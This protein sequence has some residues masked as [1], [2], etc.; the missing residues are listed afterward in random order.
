M[1]QTA[2]AITIPIAPGAQINAKH[3]LN[4]FSMRSLHRSPDTLNS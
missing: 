2:G 1:T 4:F 3:P